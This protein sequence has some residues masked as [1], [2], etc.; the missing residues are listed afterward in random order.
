MSK[1]TI[2][3]KVGF[4]VRI[5]ADSASTNDAV[6]R[7]NHLRAAEFLELIKTQAPPVEIDSVEVEEDEGEESK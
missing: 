6:D 3:A 2:V 4:T 7:V 5:P 1:Y